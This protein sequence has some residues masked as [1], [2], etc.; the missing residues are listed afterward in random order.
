V[1]A[2]EQAIRRDTGRRF[3]T[4]AALLAIVVV[5]IGFS[6][7]YYL[8]AWFE[9][10]A[11][12]LLTHVHGAVM[13]TWFVL[14]VVQTWLVSTRR[15]SLHR[16]LGTFG[17]VVAGLIVALGSAVAIRATARDAVQDAQALY[18]LVIPLGDLLAFAAM[19]AAALALRRRPAFH[20]RLMLLGSIAILPAAV[21]RFPI[22]PNTPVVFFGI[23]DLLIV[24]AA[25]YDTWKQGRLHP[26]FLWGGLFVIASHPLRLLFARTD[27]WTDFAR[28]ATG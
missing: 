19:I 28:W 21:G 26:A 15:V 6:R 7:T 20:K 25:A 24:L 14:F 9:A 11:L 12:P 22:E 4:A 10:P 16:K 1:S 27:L 18:F 8:K 23:P 5:F 13:T 3:Y 2:G 17:A